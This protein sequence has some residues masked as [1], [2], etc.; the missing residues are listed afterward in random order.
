MIYYR[1][2][3]ILF[4]ECILFYLTIV[5]ATVE[6]EAQ[7]KVTGCYEDCR[8]MS[9]ALDIFYPYVYICSG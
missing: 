8:V 3:I 4:Q 6:M 9:L 5:Y 2:F 7:T 1:V